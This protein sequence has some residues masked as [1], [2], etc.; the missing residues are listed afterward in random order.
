MIIRRTLLWCA[1][2]L[3]VSVSASHAGPR[4][5]EIDRLRGEIDNKLGTLAAAGP[6]AREST[7]A[8]MH[9]Q[10][11]PRSIGAAENG[12]GDV[13]A[14]KV[15]AVTAAMAR[16]RTADNAGDQRACEQALADAHRALGP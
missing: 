4:S 13:S 10:P 11:T 8:T 5:H 3:T 12:L 1:A 14:Q 6:A 15:E 16:A 2:A 9:R 7:A